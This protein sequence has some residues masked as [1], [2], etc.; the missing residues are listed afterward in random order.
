MS[1]L[2]LLSSKTPWG[3]GIYLGTAQQH[4]EPATTPFVFE[5]LL[6]ASVLTRIIGVFSRAPISWR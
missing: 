3:I 4:N 2:N 1:D 5:T 6:L